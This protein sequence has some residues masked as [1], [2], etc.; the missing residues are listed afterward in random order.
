MYRTIVST[1]GDRPWQGIPGI[2]RAG[3]GRLWCTFYSGGP[4]EPHP[5]NHIL[6]TTSEDEGRTWSSPEIVVDPQGPARAY[7]PALWHDPQGRLWLFYNRA[8]R[9]ADDYSLWALV[10]DESDSATPRWEG[11]RSIDLDVPF[12]FRLNKPIVTADGDWLL[13][14][15]W[16]RRAPEGW[17]PRQDQLQGVA[18]SSD[19]GQTWSLYGAVEAPPWALENMIVERRDGF[20]WML[21]RTGG[22]VLWESYSRDGARTWSPG[23]PTRIVNPGTRF[24]VRRLRSGRLLL[25]NTPDPEERRTLYASVSASADDLGAERGLQ[26]D[27]RDKVSYPDAVQAP[28]GTIYAVHDYDRRGAGE[29]VLTIFD[30]EEILAASS[31]G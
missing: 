30:E 28:D 23:A 20:L 11:P 21:I 2:E 1:K 4:K 8:Q 14:V 22:G 29:I 16:A 26:L 3:D 7:D 19:A 24:F 18:I 12:A 31:A 10:T 27:N 15:T 9:E 25:I 13:P 6:L 5:D 17:F